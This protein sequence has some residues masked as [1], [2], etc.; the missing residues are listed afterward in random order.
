MNDY[1]ANT[2]ARNPLDDPTFWREFL[3]RLSFWDPEHD[4]ELI[5][6]FCKTFD[7]DP[8]IVRARLRAVYT[9]G[10]H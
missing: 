1:R 5:K 3:K 6:D 4:A 2:V 7:V 8:A 9:F 10:L